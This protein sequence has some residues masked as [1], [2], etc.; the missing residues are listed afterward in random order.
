MRW[1]KI[2]EQTCCLKRIMLILVTLVV[3]SST[4]FI[5]ICC[6]DYCQVKMQASGVVMFANIPFLG[7]VTARSMNGQDSPRTSRDRQ[8]AALNCSSPENKL[9]EINAKEVGYSLKADRSQSLFN[10]FFCQSVSK[11]NFT[12]IKDVF[13]SEKNPPMLSLFCSLCTFLP[14]TEDYWGKME[15]VCRGVCE[16]VQCLKQTPLKISK[17]KQRERGILFK[18][19]T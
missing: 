8:E 7:S 1:L 2:E 17:L 6:L 13:K 3:T 19:K 15:N 14:L 4:C 5:V 10:T 9:L 12:L 11:D 18:G 16:P